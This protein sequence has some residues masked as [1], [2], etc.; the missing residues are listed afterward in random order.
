MYVA[1]SPASAKLFNLQASNLQIHV[2][3]SLASAKLFNLQA[4]NLQIYVAAS[5]ASAKLCNLQ[6]K[7]APDFENSNSTPP[8]PEGSAPIA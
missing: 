6:A 4:G 1:S 8:C 5:P 7:T 2:A 3:A